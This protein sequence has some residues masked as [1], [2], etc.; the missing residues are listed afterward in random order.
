M[1]RTFAEKV[2]SKN[3]GLDSVKAGEIVEARPDFVLSHDNT[4]DISRK[5][6]SIGTDSVWDPT[7]FLIRPAS[8]VMTRTYPPALV[9]L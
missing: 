9:G 7:P 6:L 2:L 5:F 8:P 1:G 4:A 3:T